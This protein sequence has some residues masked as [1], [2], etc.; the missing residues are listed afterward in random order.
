VFDNNYFYKVFFYFINMISKLP[1]SAMG[2][3]NRRNGTNLRLGL[4]VPLWRPLEIFRN[5]REDVYSAKVRARI[6][7]GL[8][9]VGFVTK[10]IREEDH[11]ASAFSGEDQEHILT[12]EFLSGAIPRCGRGRVVVHSVQGEDSRRKDYLRL[13][14]GDYGETDFSTRLPPGTFQFGSDVPRAVS[15]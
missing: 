5:V 12:Y 15:A 11:N 13:G 1:K 3:I 14:R 10:E 8:R 2:A 4:F 9:T 7:S 6:Y